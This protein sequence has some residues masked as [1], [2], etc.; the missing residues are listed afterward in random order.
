MST[1]RRLPIANEPPAERA[2]AARNRARILAA[3]R[4]LF[5]EHDPCTVSIDQ[6]AGAA[7]VGKGT[8]YRRFGDRAGLVEALLDDRERAFQA[9]VLAGPPPLGPGAPAAERLEAFLCALI[10]QLEEISDLRAE[11]EAGTTWH[12]NAPYRFRR[13]HVRILLAEAAPQVDADVLADTL[14]AP[15]ATDLY[16]YQRQV[17]GYPTDRLKGAMRTFVRGVLHC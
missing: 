3:A 13:L 12:G 1:Y 17:S 9:D 8:I 11:V 6:I 16:R 14:L 2:D 15:L 4:G 7:G 5:A 10:D